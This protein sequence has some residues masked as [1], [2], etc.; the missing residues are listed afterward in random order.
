M[1]RLWYK[2][3]QVGGYE[4]YGDLRRCID[5]HA[6]IHGTGGVQG[7]TVQVVA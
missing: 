4:F 1:Q 2:D 7:G 6:R 3:Q 5:E